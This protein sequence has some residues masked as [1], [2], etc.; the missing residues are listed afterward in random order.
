MGW[1]RGASAKVVTKV[2]GKLVVEEEEQQ[3]Q[4]EEEEEEKCFDPYRETIWNF[5]KV[6]VGE[7]RGHCYEPVR[8]RKSLPPTTLS[9]PTG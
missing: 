2:K 4:E 9:T 1:G 3:E 8:R 5:E 6:V 7:F